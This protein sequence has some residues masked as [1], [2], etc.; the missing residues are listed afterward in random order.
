MFKNMFSNTLQTMLEHQ[1]YFSFL[2]ALL[3]VCVCEFA[4]QH[5]GRFAFFPH[6]AR[7]IKAEVAGILCVHY[8]APCRR[9]I[10]KDYGL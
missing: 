9:N 8:T 7:G 5:D 10:S 6:N 2:V 4:S 1:K 3:C